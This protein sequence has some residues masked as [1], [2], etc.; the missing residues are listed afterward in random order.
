[1]KAIYTFLILL[2]PITIFSQKW[3]S[4][5]FNNHRLDFR[6]LGYPGVNEIPAD[7]SRISALITGKEG[8]IFGA[9]SGKQSHLFV[10]DQFINKVRPLGQLPNTSG[11]YHT[12]VQD[13]EGNI[14]I[15]TGL[16]LLDEIPL[17]KDFPGGHRQI[18]NQ[19]WKDIQNYELIRIQDIDIVQTMGDR[20]VGVGDI[21]IKGADLSTPS[22]VI[23]NI[24][25]TQEVYEI[26]RK[27]WLSA[28]K[29]YGLKFREDM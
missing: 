15:G 2:F 13:N 10:Y 22:V 14:Y 21:H 26:L 9:T 4:P 27:A 16:N 11:V 1:M 6:D 17:T 18:E 8:Y 28:R 24:H 29:R 19:L 7:D 5:N 20:I 3:V 12:M 23:R 25:D